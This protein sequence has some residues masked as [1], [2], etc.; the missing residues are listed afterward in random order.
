MHLH[1]VLSTPL[2]STHHQQQ[3]EQEEKPHPIVLGNLAFTTWVCGAQHPLGP[4]RT[5]G[6]G[7]GN[8]LALKAFFLVFYFYFFL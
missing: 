7:G 6:E 4:K 2:P 8:A 3:R 5:Q 1:L